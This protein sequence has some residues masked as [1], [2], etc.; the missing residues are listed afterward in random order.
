[1]LAVANSKIIIVDQ[2]WWI[3]AHLF[4]LSNWKVGKCKYIVCMHMTFIECVLLTMNKNICVGMN[5]VGSHH[6][7]VNAHIRISNNLILVRG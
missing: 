5:S 1:M 3:A 4:I 6:Q 7:S 2:W